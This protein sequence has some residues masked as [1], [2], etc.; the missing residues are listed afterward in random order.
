[1]LDRRCLYEDSATVV[2]SDYFEI[3]ATSV[4]SKPEQDFTAA[5]RFQEV[6]VKAESSDRT[7]LNHKQEEIQSWAAS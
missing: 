3:T 7:T 2:V 4:S 5:S 1:M 6:T